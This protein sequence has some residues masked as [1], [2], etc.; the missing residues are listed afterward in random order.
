MAFFGIMAGTFIALAVFMPG[1][2]GKWLGKIRKAY[3][4]EMGN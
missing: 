1:E 4:K 2:F 3:D